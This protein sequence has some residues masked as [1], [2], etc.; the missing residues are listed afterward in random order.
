MTDTVE[1]FLGTKQG[2]IGSEH[3]ETTAAIQRQQLEYLTN[4][5]PCRSTLY[6][7]Q[8]APF[9]NLVFRSHVKN[10]NGPMAVAA[11]KTVVLYP[12]LGVGHLNPMVELAKLFLRRG[13]AVVD[14]PDKDS[15]SAAAVA[16]LA[17]ANPAIAFR[18]LPAPPPIVPGCV[19]TLPIWLSPA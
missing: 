16:R 9:L 10:E 4:E 7:E 5:T 2:R 6:I 19:N 11:P 3:L 15:V 8:V 18:L 13:L 17:A 12:S 14:S 1:I